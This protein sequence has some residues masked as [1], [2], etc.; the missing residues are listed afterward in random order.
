MGCAPLR[1]LSLL[2]VFSLLAG[3]GSDGTPPGKYNSPSGAPQ[4]RSYSAPAEE[5]GYYKVGKPYQVAGLW[6]HP[7]E[8]FGYVETGVASWYGPDFQ[9]QPTANGETYDMYALTAAHRTL[10]MPSVVRVT[11]Q[12]NGRSVIVRINDRGPFARERIID[13]SL[14]AAEQLGMTGR[15]T[16]QV[17]VEVLPDESLRIAE[18]A[19]TGADAARLDEFMA[20]R[21]GQGGGELIAQAAQKSVPQTAAVAEPRPVL[22]PATYEVPVRSG[23]LFV[24]AGAFSMRDNA[25]RLRSEL[26]RFGDARVESVDINGRMLHRVRLGPLGSVD[27]AQATLSRLTQNGYSVAQ[28]VVE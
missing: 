4:G 25:E 22:Q 9:G 18:L 16:A 7:R 26:A 5:R 11:N 2:S 17:R 13:L 10:Q 6:Y 1:L 8:D 24:Q 23:S 28:V 19:K 12:T 20:R 15:G 14:R 3:C 21:F 27:I